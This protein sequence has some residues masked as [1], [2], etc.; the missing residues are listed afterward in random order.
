MELNIAVV[1]RDISMDLTRVYQHCNPGRLV[2]G[3]NSI[4]ELKSFIS[5]GEKLLIITDGGVAK[6]GILKSVTDVLEAS[7][8]RYEVFEE[9]VPNPPVDVIKKAAR[10]YKEQRCSMVL[11]LGGGSSLDGAKAVG[12]LAG[13]GGELREFACG[14][15]IEGELCRIFAVPT[16]A[17]TGSEVTAVTVIT[18]PVS[19]MKMPIKAPQLIPS[20]VFLDPVL[21]K[22]I[23]PKVAAETGADA[24]VHAIEAYVSNNSNAVTDALA[25]SAIRLLAANLRKIVSDSSDLEILNNMLLGSCI[26]GLSFSNAGLGLVH[27]LAHP[28]GAYYNFGHGLVC[29]LYLPSVMEFNLSA[30]QD[31]F[32]DIADAMGEDVRGLSVGKAAER[33]IEA[34]RSLFSDIK[35]PGTFADAGISFT[36]YP[37]MVEDA[38]AAGPT[39]LNP[40]RSEKEDL[41]RLFQSVK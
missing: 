40:K 28:V 36:L 21:M 35:I 34:V 27:S 13:T 23:P 3:P 11:G 26:A 14:K 10:L 4:R 17:G 22:G 7:G 31:K 38:F 15:P 5:V 25:L 29:A 16:T 18:D 41:T 2:F 6:V 37:K 32:A 24:L 30:C 12:I 19:K 20:V 8:I 33:A 9:I 39:K 1:R